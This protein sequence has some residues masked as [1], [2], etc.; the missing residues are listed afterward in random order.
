[1][2]AA[3]QAQQVL[4]DT[5]PGMRVGNVTTLAD[6]MDKTLVTERVVATLAGMVGGVG[7]ML[8][9]VGVFG[10]LAYTVTRRTR[11][12]GIRVALGATR[13]EIAR[14]ILAGAARPVALGLAIGLALA[15]GAQRLAASVVEGPTA[16]EWRPVAV[17]ALSIVAVAVVAAWLP[18]RRAAAIRPVE[19]LR[20]D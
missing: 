19:A 14:M 12:I 15:F 17:A 3:A 11:E 13:G 18:A 2:A 5:V 1:M 20:H 7:S 6:Q 8:V 10:L 9:A 16:N 4:R